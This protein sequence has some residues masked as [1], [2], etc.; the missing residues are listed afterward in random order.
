MKKA[1]RQQIK[2]HNVQLILKTIYDDGQISRADIARS[3]RLT[4]TTV[5]EAVAELIREG[6]V[7]ESGWGPSAGGKPPILLSVN[8]DA[9]YLIGVDLASSEFRG[10]VVNLRGQIWRSINLPLDGRIGQDALLLAEQLIEQLAAA[11]P[12]AVMGIGIGAP[13]LM[14]TRGGMILNAVN[15]GWY[16]LP[17]GA[18]LTEK[19]DLP[20]YIANDCQAAALS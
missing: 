5:S 14:D 15:L 13:G 8:G 16:N 9:R 17:L 12:G 4:P 1:T 10:A 18:R 6:L 2:T 3:T 20:V 11:A 7:I 19:Y